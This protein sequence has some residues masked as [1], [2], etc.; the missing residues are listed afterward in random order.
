[1]PNLLTKESLR[2]SF[3]AKVTDYFKRTASFVLEETK[4]EVFELGERMIFKILDGGLWYCLDDFC[5]EAKKLLGNKFYVGSMIDINNTF[6]ELLKNTPNH[7]IITKL[8]DVSNYKELDFFDALRMVA[9]LK[10]ENLFEEV[11]CVVIYLKE[12]K[13]DKYKCRLTASKLRSGEIYVEVG[14]ILYAGEWPKGTWIL[15]RTINDIRY[16]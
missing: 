2:Q 9:I 11:S 1:M 6:F 4:G 16:F 14:E 12:M 10:R 15:G 5:N 13:D 3:L 8:Q 7:A